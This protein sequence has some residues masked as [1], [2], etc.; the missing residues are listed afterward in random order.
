MYIK[1]TKTNVLIFSA[2]SFL[3]LFPFVV[4]LIISSSYRPL[5]LVICWSAFVIFCLIIF[6]REIFKK[7]K[8]MNDRWVG[9]LGGAGGVLVLYPLVSNFYWPQRVDL[10]LFILFEVMGLFL[11]TS[12]IIIHRRKRRK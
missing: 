12:G 6:R 2:A 9:A 5:P 8:T 1:V 11:I 10:I 4:E 7:N 3:L